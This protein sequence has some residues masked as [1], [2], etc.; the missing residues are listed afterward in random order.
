VN[1]ND[2]S[3]PNGFTIRAEKCPNRRGVEKI[4]SRINGEL[5][6][7]EQF[8]EHFDPAVYGALWLTGGYK[9]DWIDEDTAKRLSATRT[10]I[11]QD[12][13]A[14]PIWNRATYQL[15]GATFAEREGSYVNHADRLQ[16][17]TWAIRAPAG[18]HV[19]GRLYW[20]LLGRAGLYKSRSVLEEVATEI[21][22]FAAALEPV[23]A[24]GVDLKVNML[25]G[26][27]S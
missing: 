20:Q 18:V 24:T 14:S 4:A 5:V 26:A 6:T 11:V 25:A 3:F 15:P 7:W 2:E 9:T 17:F 27:T 13:F 21:A 12:C 1:G 8:L 16:T 23:P 19:E 22:Y 10:V